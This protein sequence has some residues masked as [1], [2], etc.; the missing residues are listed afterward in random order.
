MF[1]YR[2]YVYEKYYNKQ[3]F[4]SDWNKTLDGWVFFIMMD[5]IQTES[6][7]IYAVFVFNFYKYFC[8]S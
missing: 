3:N 6:I 2:Q 8:L 5:Y 7:R 4:N 1:K